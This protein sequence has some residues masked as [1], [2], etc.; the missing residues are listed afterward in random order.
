MSELTLTVPNSVSFTEAIAFTNS[1]LD[2]MEAGKVN[3][4]QIE[5][6]IAS[7]VQS[8]NGARGFFV[9]YLTDDR[10]FAD[11][12]SNAVILALKSAPEVVSELLVKNVAMSAA[13]AVTHR[14]DRNEEMAESSDRVCRRTA[15]LIQQM[16]LDSIFDRVEKLRE[17]V[18]T[19]TGVY[20]SFLQR[21][22]YDLEQKQ[23]I[24]KALTQLTK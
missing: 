24:E 11:R 1:L 12:P 17:S 19:D 22:G 18:T 3:E 10:P 2:R 16:Q 13:M 9:T 20:Q 15:N 4:A 5:E 6:A 7:L 23:V 8:E 14:R 21:W